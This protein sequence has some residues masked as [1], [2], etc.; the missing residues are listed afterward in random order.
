MP[1]KVR[2][3]TPTSPG[4]ITVEVDRPKDADLIGYEIDPINDRPARYFI[5]FYTDGGQSSEIVT[6]KFIPPV[7]HDP[8]DSEGTSFTALVVVKD[9]VVARDRKQ[10]RNARSVREGKQ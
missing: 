5:G 1:Y 9:T 7:A 3:I 4:K 8:D 10:V 6:D 2:V